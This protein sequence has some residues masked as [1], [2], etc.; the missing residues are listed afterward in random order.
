MLAPTELLL[1]RKPTTTRTPCIRPLTPPTAPRPSTHRGHIV[2]LPE[3]GPLVSAGVSS[4]PAVE[5]T[6]EA[7]RVLNGARIHRAAAPTEIKRARQR[8]L[9]LLIRVPTP[10]PITN[11]MLP[12]ALAMSR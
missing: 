8:S 10:R 5:A 2:A 1:A 12:R 11:P 7:S 4:P 3:A 6:V 9:G